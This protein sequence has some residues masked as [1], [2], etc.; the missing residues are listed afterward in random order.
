MFD[1]LK[2][3]KLEGDKVVMR[4]E[5]MHCSSCAVNIDFALE[6]LDGVSKSQ[7]NF[8]SGKLEIE[9][10]PKKVNLD[11]IKKVIKKQGYIPVI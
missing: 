6:D 1:F 5:G 7:T 11:T 3:Q 9:F 8:A 10:N 4:I 2:K